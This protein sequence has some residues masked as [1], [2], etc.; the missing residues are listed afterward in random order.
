MAL[1]IVRVE[2]PELFT[3]PAER[4]EQVVRV[5]VA[6]PPGPVT[7]SVLS[8]QETVQLPGG[9]VTVE[10]A[11]DLT[12][13]A[14]GTEVP[15]TV[16]VTGP[17]GSATAAARVPVAEPGWTAYLV[18]HFHYDPVWWTT[19]A[20][21]TSAWDE[22]TGPDSARQAFQ[23]A[24]FDLVRAHL[25]TARHDPDYRFVL[26]ETD[27]LKPWWD[28]VPSARDE[29][30]RLLAEGRCELVGG[31]Y[32][33]P[34]TNLTSVES[35]VRNLAYGIALQRDVLGGS[36]ET[37]WQL[38]A[39]GHDPQFPGLCA[40]AGLTA[41][42]WARGPFH[43]WGPMQT[44]GA[45]GDAR[46][47]QFPSEFEWVAPS[48]TG[49]L[50][51]YMPAH[52]SAGWWMDSAATLDDALAAVHALF[53]SLK[54][55]AATRNV[56]IPVGTDYSPPNKWVTAIH[57]EQA[58]RYTWPRFVCAT[59]R[60]FLAAVRSGLA[61]EGRAA[62]PVSRDMNPVYTGKDVSYIDTKQANRQ[63]EVRVAD[64]ERFATLA[65]LHGARFPH[66]ALDLAWRQLLYGA[67][68]D[69]VT[70]SEGDQVY[71]DLLAGWRAAWTTGGD[72]LAAAAADLVSQVDTS[73]AGPVV[74]VLNGLNWAR[75]ELV[76]VDLPAGDWSLLD[77]AGAPV[78]AVLEGRTLA[79]VARDLPATGWRTYRLVAGRTPAWRPVPGTTAANE[80]YRVEVDPARGGTVTS[81][82]DRRLGRELLPAGQT[83]NEL[84]LYDEYP[85]HPTFGEGPWH[86]LPTGPPRAGSSRGPA[87]VRA[88]AAPAGERLVVTGS[89]DGIDYEQT[90]T[91]WTGLSRVDCSTR[92]A[93]TGADRL[94]RL[95]WPTDV[96]GGLPVSEV[97]AAVIGRGYGV[98]DVDSAEHPWTLDNP[99]Y[100]WF[101]VGS[102]ARVVADGV[103]TAMGVAEV[104][105]DAA[106]AA[107][108]DLVVALVRAGVTS[109]T[110]LDTGSRYGALAV[111]SNLP[112]TRIAV[113]G[114]DRNAF[115][116]AVLAAAPAYREEL[117][118]QLADTGRARVWVPAERPLPEVWVPSAD[119][120]GVRT[121]PV[122]IVAGV[123]DGALAAALSDLVADLADATVHIG[124]PASGNGP[125][126]V[127]V[128]LLSRGLPGFAVDRTGAMHLS[129]ARSCTGWPSAVWISKPRRT[130]PDGSGFQLQH[131]THTFEY[132]LASGP[133]DWRS[134]GFV[135]AGQAFTAP[136]VAVVA[137][138]HPGP[139]PPVH[140]LLSVEPAGAAVV[141]AVKPAG[142]P[143]AS[144][145]APAG[146]ADGV[147]VRLYEA[148]GQRLT[149]RVRLAG[150]VTGAQRCDLLDRPTGPL[151]VAADGA[152]EVP[153]GPCEVATVLLHPAGARPGDR[154]LVPE[155]AG[156]VPARYWL[157]NAG[158]AP[159]GNLP[160]SVHAEPT[161]VTGPVELT[162][163]VSSSLADAEWTGVVAVTADE[164]WTVTPAATPVALPP[165]GWAALPVRVAPAADAPPGDHLVA[166]SIEHAGQVVRD[167]VQVTVPGP[168]PSP[169]ALDVHI[170][171]LAVQ[172]RPGRPATVRI[173]VSST[174]R[175][176]LE[177]RLELL[178]PVD[179]WPFT[180]QWTVPVSL[181]ADDRRIVELP[182]LAPAGTPPGEWWLLARLSGAGQVAYSAT[183]P[184]TI[185]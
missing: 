133:G 146:P 91:V 185:S 71:L 158:P 48:G 132:A 125:D 73:G 78:P 36:P 3:G 104:V 147:V 75:T 7:V 164:G 168:V 55:V 173:E 119:L 32:N 22:L 160:V 35:T 120:R 51:A 96:P 65:G 124:Q 15:A 62:V 112:D 98:V 94:L 11:V 180:P 172:L 109:T 59:P 103:T 8:G 137:E 184:L 116:A 6:G 114:P 165:G 77:E 169:G 14:V 49:L 82:L 148:A 131:W 2:H 1:S 157:E 170:D 152:V 111:D 182:V 60:E 64:G 166:V 21:Y 39:F 67:H 136:P 5:T 145:R 177:A 105:A 4:P 93:P 117:D 89:A 37:A 100:S 54:P 18:P 155:P 30:R 61:A 26:A 174:Y 142:S 13:Q 88:W 45:S 138:P 150:G 135:P 86:L 140:S 17:A 16:T 52:Y 74:T 159:A 10:V 118:R 42:S 40:G 108:R 76:R 28:T 12:G 44:H 79:F 113:G 167:L 50:T 175:S 38:D 29:L 129:L 20:A 85:Q 143:L 178:G 156:V 41:S 95:R 102:T 87:T 123:D 83:G 19:Q 47:M 46:V 97:G 110:S 130:V 9:E 127:S 68:H 63:A 126:A 107:V 23:L 69:A 80:A 106:G 128:A 24:G 31:T 25:D 153:L 171:T 99:A 141:T 34:N 139:L 101:G 162:V 90:L 122:L 33:E 163:S 121:L 66:A 56:L 27:Y 115:T 149:A 81:W 134:A 181:R 183:V 179:T 53:L 151:A 43:Q 144:G 70:G 57:R 92:L 176:P 161:R 58:A 154:E 72:V 84:L